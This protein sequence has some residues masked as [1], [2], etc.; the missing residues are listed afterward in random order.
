MARRSNNLEVNWC[1]FYEISLVFSPFLIGYLPLRLTDLGF[2][3]SHYLYWSPVYLPSHLAEQW[4]KNRNFQNSLC[5]RQWGLPVQAS[6]R[7]HS[8]TS[9]TWMYP[10]FQWMISIQISCFI[11]R[12]IL[13]LW[14]PTIIKS[15]IATITF[16]MESRWTTFTRILS[17]CWRHIRFGW[18]KWRIEN[19]VPKYHKPKFL[20]FLNVP[21]VGPQLSYSWFNL[22]GKRSNFRD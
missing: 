6:Y 11:R 7:H 17:K 15:S 21:L 3:F 13:S 20:L 8:N 9:R 5:K 10:N 2:S 16:Q 14:A 19:S 22:A 18:F 12:G 1:A 4:Y